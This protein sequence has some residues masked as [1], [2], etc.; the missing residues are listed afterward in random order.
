MHKARLV[1]FRFG[2][3]K[4]HLGAASHAVRVLVETFGLVLSHCPPHGSL[5]ALFKLRFHNWKVS[6][7]NQN[8]PS[9]AKDVPHG[10]ARR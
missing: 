3:G 5:M 1:R 6:A 4:S 9:H 10:E 8:L 7:A 2:T